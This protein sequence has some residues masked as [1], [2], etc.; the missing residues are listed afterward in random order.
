[1]VIS[2]TELFGK[3]AINVFDE[4]QNDSRNFT[5]NIA[6]MKTLQGDNQPF[7]VMNAGAVVSALQQWFT[8]LPRVSPFYS[9]RW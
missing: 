5:Q 1:M 7:Y 4:A 3:F 2:H 6:Q 8:Y 9:V